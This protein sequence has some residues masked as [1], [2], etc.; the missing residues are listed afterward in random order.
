MNKTL[1]NK[2]IAMIIAYKDF[3]DEEYFIPRD[4]FIQQGAVVVTVSKEQGIA[5]GSNGGETKVDLSLEE[6]NSTDF[7]A[8]VFVGG[9]GMA[10]NIDN[11]IHHYIVR[12]TIEA[13]KIL[14]AICIAPLILARAGALKGKKATVWSNLIDKHAVKILKEEGVVYQ[15]EPVVVDGNIITG[16]SPMSAKEFADT[17]AVSLTKK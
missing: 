13:K 15:D 8:V 16:R 14:A 4:I 3:R 12:E 5:I 7:D 17:I 9:S 6:L 10:K 11:E 1:E 2:K